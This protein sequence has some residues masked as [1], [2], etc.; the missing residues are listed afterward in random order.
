MNKRP[1]CGD[2]TKY[3]M[4]KKTLHGELSPDETFP[5]IDV[6]C[7]AF[8]KKKGNDTRTGNKVLNK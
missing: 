6:P 7:E 4:C 5:E 3:A 8:R 1:R 2:C